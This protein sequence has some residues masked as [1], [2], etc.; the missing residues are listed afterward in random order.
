MIY[1]WKSFEAPR[2]G[3]GVSELTNP[4]WHRE[5][6]LF[7]GHDPL[8]LPR[9]PR[10]LNTPENYDPVLQEWYYPGIVD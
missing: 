3:A 4:N 5:L 2:F 7:G 6:I 1:R 9:N 8:T 10:F